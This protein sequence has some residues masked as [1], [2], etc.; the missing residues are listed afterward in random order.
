VPPDTFAQYLADVEKLILRS[1]T[2]SA[3]DVQRIRREFS[4]LLDDIVA[5]LPRQI[6]LSNEAVTT[7]LND[8][9]DRIDDLAVRYHATFVGGVT[10]QMELSEELFKIYGDAFLE[11]RA[12]PL[13]G[14]D[15]RLLD[16]ASG[17][18]ADLIK[19]VTDEIKKRIGT[20]LRLGALGLTRG[21]YNASAEISKALGTGAGLTYRAE[22]IYRTE[23]LRIFSLHTQANME[24]MN[25]VVP[26]DKVWMW[27]G[28]SRIEHAKINGQR[29]KVHEKFRVPRK[30]GGSVLM[31]HPRD[32]S[33]PPDATINCGCYTYPVPR[34]FVQERAGGLFEA[35]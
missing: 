14:T 8:L 23:T 11:F 32:P 6:Q 27:S 33:A 10:A 3:A 17:Y 13:I 26:M 12:I 19:D 9:A 21:A 20:T 25:E 16:L 5:S 4:S 7:I 28:I 30:Q 1:Q 31:K 24:L 29:R 35:V 2:L 34:E 22:R 15:P 18:S